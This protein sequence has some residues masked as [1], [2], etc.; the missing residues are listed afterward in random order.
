MNPIDPK[1]P[2]PDSSEIDASLRVPLLALFGGAAL[3]LVVG[4][5]FGLLAG[6]KF[7]A[8]DFLGACPLMTYGRL[9]PA[10]NDA[11]LYGFAIPAALGVIL[12]IMSRLSGMP[13]ALPIVPVVAANIW[14]LGVLVGIG[15]ILIGES[16]GYPWLEFPRAA[17]VLLFAAFLLIAVSVAATFG[18]RRQREL[19]PAH[20]FLFAALLWFPWIYSS[21]NLF[22]TAVHVPRGMVQ[23]VIDW[24]FGNNLLFVWLGLAGVGI[25]FYFL[26]KIGGRPLATSGYALFG[27]LTLIFF[28]T[29]CGI[30]V[31]APVPAW[32]PT[33]STIASVLSIPAVFA[34]AI[35][36]LRT[37]WG[38]KV[39][40]VGGPFHFVRF[41]LVSFVLGSVLYLGNGCP[42]IGHLVQFTWYGVGQTQLTLLGFFVMVVLGG[43]YEILTSTSGLALPFPKL[44]KVHYYLAMPG[45]LLYALPLV[46]GGVEQGIRMQNPAIPFADANAAALFWLRISSTGQILLVLGS[47]LLVLNIFVMTIKWKIALAKSVW[48]AVT[49]PLPVTEVKA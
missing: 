33:V 8:P 20:W 41:G 40:Y 10:A 1:T 21:A 25:A 30:P 43:I 27:F 18:W 29:W 22:L 17:A 28:G 3:W 26:P 2:A 19:F 39:K 4:L 48:A 24:W 12:C 6:I 14:N 35:V 16:T 42:Q 37:A 34:I 44:A 23:A 5:V 49:S 38:A 32:L 47:L 9:A 7:H 36:S 31:G 15:G 45:V 46:I 13:V 11:V